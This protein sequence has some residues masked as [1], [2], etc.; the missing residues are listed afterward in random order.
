[1]LAV[2]R[3]LMG[4][5]R[6]VMIDEMSLGLA[7]IVVQRMLPVIRRIADDT[8]AGIVVVEQHVHLALEVA[9]RGVVLSHGEVIAA[10][11]ASELAADRALLEAGYFGDRT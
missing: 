8:G 9:D 11:P 3:A 4:R 1:M 10:G 5:P 6:L 2:A 7:P